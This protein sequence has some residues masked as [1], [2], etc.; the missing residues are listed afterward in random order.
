MQTDYPSI[1]ILCRIPI[2]PPPQPVCL[3]SDYLCSC[4]AAMDNS[5]SGPYWRAL[6]QADN[7]ESMRLVQEK[8]AIMGTE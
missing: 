8:R 7:R 5:T 6:E 2:A 3:L 1:C 4:C